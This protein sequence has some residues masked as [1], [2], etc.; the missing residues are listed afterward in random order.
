ITEI[1]I[2]EKKTKLIKK[3]F[4]DYTN[5]VIKKEYVIVISTNTSY[6]L[7]QKLNGL[8]ILLFDDVCIFI[9]KPK[10]IEVPKIPQLELLQKEEFEQ[11][12]YEHLRNKTKIL[13]S[14]GFETPKQI[15]CMEKILEFICLYHLKYQEKYGVP[16][17]NFEQDFL[18]KLKNM[19]SI[20][21]NTQFLHIFMGRK[22]EYL[23]EQDFYYNKFL[24]L[25]I[26]FQGLIPRFNAPYR[27][28]IFNKK[29]SEF[30]LFE[31]FFLCKLKVYKLIDCSKSKQ[32]NYLLFLL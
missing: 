1:M 29:G 16:K 23:I 11:K 14:K 32:E 19:I 28:V 18:I 7:Q 25:E 9:Y 31:Y 5:E 8:L 6:Y 3:A 26:D 12:K 13:I 15:D 2:S 17:S 27:I 20:N 24:E 4:H 22:T 10:N 30:S 21:S